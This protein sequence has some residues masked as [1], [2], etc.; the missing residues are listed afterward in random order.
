MN[1]LELLKKDHQKVAKILSQ[2]EATTQ[3]A[4]YKREELFD[5]LE[6]EFMIHAHFEEK[7][8]YPALKGEAETKD[9]ILEAYEEH[10]AVKLMLKELGKLNADDEKWVARLKVIKEN[11]Q[12]HVDEEEN[13]LFPQVEA[14]LPKERLLV[15]AKRYKEFKAENKK[16]YS[17]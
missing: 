10:H 11:I 3:R 4:V 13:E 9:L 15:L 17:Y 1:I 14:F 16:A 2:L 7:M 8:F 6:A 12:H 5:K